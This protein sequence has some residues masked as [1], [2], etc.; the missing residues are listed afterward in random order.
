MEFLGIHLALRILPDIPAF[1]YSSKKSHTNQS[2]ADFSLINKRLSNAG[3]LIY[4]EMTCTSDDII[5]LYEDLLLITGTVRNRITNCVYE[6]PIFIKR[7][8]S[9]QG[10]KLL[11]SR[12]LTKILVLPRTTTI[13]NRN[14]LFM[15]SSLIHHILIDETKRNF[16]WKS[17]DCE[18][19]KK[20]PMTMFEH[21]KCKNRTCLTNRVDEQYQINNDNRNPLTTT[22]IHKF[23]LAT[24]KKL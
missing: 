24:G 18:S 8:L 1:Q 15:N 12:L 22:N 23:L 5:Q 3:L 2:L 19:F 11:D 21:I 10:L 17:N 4:N 7:S 16:N 9:K 6:A 20:S 14:N 13:V